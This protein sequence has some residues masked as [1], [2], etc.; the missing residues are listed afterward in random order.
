MY[1]LI[2]KKYM[3]HL[4]LFYFLLGI[5]IFD[6]LIIFS[7]KAKTIFNAKLLTALNNLV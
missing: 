6:F 3:N 1:R 2:I 4:K 7:P 5:Y